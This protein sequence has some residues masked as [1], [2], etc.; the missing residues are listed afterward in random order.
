MSSIGL[1]GFEKLQR[2][3]R[4]ETDRDRQ[5]QTET[6]RDRQRQTETDRDRQR[7]R[8]SYGWQAPAVLQI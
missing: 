6:D 7:Q 5:R 1:C 4:T 3:I 8:K 2:K